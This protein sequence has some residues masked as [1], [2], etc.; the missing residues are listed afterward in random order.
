MLRR[1]LSGAQP[2][3]LLP[4]K[5]PTTHSPLDPF[6]SIQAI[7]HTGP[8]GPFFPNSNS[9]CLNFNLIGWLELSSSPLHHNFY[10]RITIFLLYFML[11]TIIMDYFISNWYPKRKRVSSLDK[12]ASQVM[13]WA[14]LISIL[15][16]KQKI[17][18]L[19]FIALNS[20]WCRTIPH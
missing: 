7:L 5:I 20:Q 6:L 8:T 19:L 1:F 10:L 13:W 9:K 15:L 11:G 14:A 3:P 12:V 18:L 2:L 4:H 16:T 17:Q